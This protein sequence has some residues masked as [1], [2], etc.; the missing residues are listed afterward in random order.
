MYPKLRLATLIALASF[1]FLTLP[2]VLPA[3]I[4]LSDS[5][6]AQ[7]TTTNPNAI[8]LKS[9]RPNIYRSSR[10]AKTKQY[11]GAANAG[12]ARTGQFSW[13]IAANKEARTRN[14]K[15]KQGRHR[16]QL[17]VNSSERTGRSKSGTALRPATT[18]NSH[19][20]N[21]NE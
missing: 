7:K 11:R 12:S 1:A 16:Q 4:G 5:A 19:K 13:D 9:F 3:S 17:Q 2:P 10:N 20:S 8:S 18:I 14:A 15:I 6:L 21:Q